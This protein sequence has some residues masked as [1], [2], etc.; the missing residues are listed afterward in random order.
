MFFSYRIA[1]K[2][3]TGYTPCQFS[4]W[5]A[6]FL[7]IEYVML[8]FNGDHIDANPIRVFTSKL[9]ELEKLQNDKLQAEGTIGSQ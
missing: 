4:L 6:S 5:I 2:V 8:A 7:P 1:Y 9:I 3:A